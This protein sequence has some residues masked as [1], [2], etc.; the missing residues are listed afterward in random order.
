MIAADDRCQATHLPRI[1]AAFRRTLA[2]HPPGGHRLGKALELLCAQT[3][4]GRNRLMS[5]RVRRLMTTWPGA[6]N[7]CSLAARFGVVPTTPCSCV[8]PSP[9]RSPTTTAPVAMPTRPTS[10]ASPPLTRPTDCTSSRP[11]A[12]RT[13]G[14]V[15]V[16]PRPAEVGEHAIAHEL[17]HMPVP[18]A[19]PPRRSKPDRLGSRRSCPRDRVF[20]T[21][22]SSPPDHRTAPLAAAAR[23][24]SATL[25]LVAKK[26]AR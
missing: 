17:G 22:R 26:A 12:H 24:R 15:L 16:R 5:R 4:R 14:I 1:E 25:A 11:G 8:A 18:S 23:H 9:I 6:A 19:S 13:L 21:A 7:P 2:P 20:P 10:G 3:P